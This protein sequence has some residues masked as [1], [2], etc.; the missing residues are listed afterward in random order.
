MGEAQYRWYNAKFK[1]N[2]VG[3]S[4][5]ILWEKKRT[6]E[7]GEIQHFDSKNIAFTSAKLRKLQLR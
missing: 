5:K 2:T 1:Y 4:S 6:E 3:S 7:S